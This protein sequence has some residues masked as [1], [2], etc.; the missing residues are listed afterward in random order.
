M[1]FQ[2]GPDNKLNAQVGMHHCLPRH[3]RGGGEADYSV[4]VK[5]LFLL[6]LFMRA[7]PPSPPQEETVLYVAGV[8]LIIGEDV[9][10]DVFGTFELNF[11]NS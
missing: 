2:Y 4:V 3:Q 10:Q 9:F 7:P 11:S 8:P 5:M 1:S 6:A